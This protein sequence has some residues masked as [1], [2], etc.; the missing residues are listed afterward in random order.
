MLNNY[1]PNIDISSLIS[2]DFNDDNY[3]NVAKEI[4]KASEEIGFFTVTGH[5]ISNAKIDKLLSTCRH[6]F[7]STNEEKLKIAPKKWNPN[8]N[9]VYRGYFPSSVNGK[10]GLDIGDPQL[11]HDMKDLLVKEKF[12]V[13]HDM[14]YLN[15]EWQIVIDDYYNSIFELGMRLFKSII[16]AYSSNLDLANKAFVRPKTL[17]TLRFNFYPKQDKPVEI[18]EQDGVA[19]GCETH[20]DSGIMTIL[21]QDKKGGLQVQNRHTLEWHD[22]PHDPNAYVVNSGL[23]LEY[24]TNGKM[25]ATNH[26]V[27]FNQEERISIPFFFEPSYDFKLDPKY[28]EI[29][30]EQKY[31]IDNY[32]DFLTNS[33]KK[34]VEYDRPN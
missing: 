3:K 34:F 6:F 9:T 32:E 33:L 4:K 25:K 13:N 27:L 1:I 19:L 10:E 31:D 5:G 28:L 24:L 11:S 23:A 22:V 7:H 12:E 20:V 26:R 2:S 14:S 21:Y 17:S 15:P 16:S 8:T 29:Q 18:S 30:E